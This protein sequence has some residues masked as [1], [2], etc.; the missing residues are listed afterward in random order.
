MVLVPGV[1][2]ESHIHDLLDGSSFCNPF[3]QQYNIYFK[4]CFASEFCLGSIH[5][6]LLWYYFLTKMLR[7]KVV[8]KMLFKTVFLH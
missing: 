1:M 3:S 5:I 4:F 2:Q 8:F 7:D 6:N